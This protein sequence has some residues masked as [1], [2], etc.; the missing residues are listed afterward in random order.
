MTYAK[1]A[2]LVLAIIFCVW[3]GD[4]RENKGYQAGSAAIQVKWDADKAQIQK[5]VDIALAAATAQKEK[6]LADNETIQTTYQGQLAAAQSTAADLAD[7]LRKLE[8]RIAAGS[9][10]LPKADGGPGPVNPTPVPSQ[11]GFNTAL[12]DRLLECAANEAQLSALIAEIK[13]QL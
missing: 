8:A 9:D 2:A 13:P 7:R 3:Y 6:A 12:A 10:H 5:A 4:H 11:D 1:I